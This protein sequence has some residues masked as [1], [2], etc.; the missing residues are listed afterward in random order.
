MESPDWLAAARSPLAGQTSPG[1]DVAWPYLGDSI[2]LTRWRCLEHDARP[3][4]DK[5]Q[6]WHVVG[7]I[8]GGSF[9]LRD[10]VTDGVADSTRLVLYNPW[11]SYETSHPCGCGDR[12]GSL[13]LREDLA[14]SL[15]GAWDGA[16]GDRAAEAVFPSTLVASEARLQAEF[17]SLLRAAERAPATAESL[18]LEERAIGIAARA[19]ER[20]VGHSRPIAPI[21]PPAARGA[22]RRR[23]ERVSRVQELL[24]DRMAD[25]PRLA[26]LAAEVGISVFQLCREFRAA[27]GS[28]VH[29]YLTR[30]RLDH[31]AERIESGRGGDL[32]GLAHD[33][34][35]SSHSHFTSTFRAEFGVSPSAVRSAAIFR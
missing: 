34:G 30:L 35:F 28:T 13:V 29:R 22:E 21:A 32:S 27:T 2:A 23:L 4:G 12:G 17:W 25:G 16:V 8:R 24:W 11:S 31:A 9:R 6:R 1:V 14:R 19:V 15:V 33:L 10:R 7:F 20:L 5:H 3:R 26:E 18:E